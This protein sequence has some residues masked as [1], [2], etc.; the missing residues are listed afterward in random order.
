MAITIDKTD[1]AIE[2]VHL[3]KEEKRVGQ[4]RLQHVTERLR[5]VFA[6]TEKKTD[7]VPVYVTCLYNSRASI[8]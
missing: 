2:A 8:S 5:A 3:T 4:L 1:A 6:A 7:K